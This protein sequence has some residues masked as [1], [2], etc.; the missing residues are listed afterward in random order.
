MLKTLTW[1]VGTIGL[2]LALSSFYYLGWMFLRPL[3]KMKG[4]SRPVRGLGFVL[5]PFVVPTLF[6]MGM[7][8]S[9][10]SSHP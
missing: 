1:T 7:T 9:H 2:V 4:Y 3:K 10:S 5:S 8:R 6:V